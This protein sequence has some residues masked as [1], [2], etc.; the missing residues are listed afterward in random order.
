MTPVVEVFRLAFLGVSAIDPLYLIYSAV[1]AV[2]IC[3][4]GIM[5]FSH[6]EATFM[7][8]V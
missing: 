8:T 7:D 1:F 3:F 5:A 2:L 6:V 4:V